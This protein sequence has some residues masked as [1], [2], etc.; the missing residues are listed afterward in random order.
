MIGKT[1]EKFSLRTRDPAE[2]RILFAKAA[3][4]IEVQWSNLRRG[5]MSLTSK[6]AWVSR[7]RLPRLC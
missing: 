6:Q 7:E 5:R 4:E 1:E 2:A 3:A